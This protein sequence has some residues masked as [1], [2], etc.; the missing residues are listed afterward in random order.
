M[1]SEDPL[2][3][4]AGALLTDTLQALS[5]KIKSGEATAADMAVALNACKAL[6]IERLAK[7]GGKTMKAAGT[8]LE[9]LPFAGTDSV[10]G[11]PSH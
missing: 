4:T 5:K 9:N 1:A 8:L 11:I 7:P 10:G 6:G 3:D 2:L